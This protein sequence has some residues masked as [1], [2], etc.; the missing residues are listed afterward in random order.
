[1]VIGKIPRVMMTLLSA[2][3]WIRGMA[4]LSWLSVLNCLDFS[5]ASAVGVIVAL[6]GCRPNMHPIPQNADPRDRAAVTALLAFAEDVHWNESGRVIGISL[7]G[8]TMASAHVKQIAVFSDLEMLQLMAP[9][10]DED[11][12]CLELLPRLK[13][14]D[15]WWT[16]V[17]DAGVEHISSIETLKSL[18]LSHTKITDKSLEYL[19]RLENLETLDVE[20]T[21]V[22]PAALERFFQKRPK[23]KVRH[24]LQ[25]RDSGYRQQ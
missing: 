22:S 19:A 3:R 7:V 14:L 23:C 13:A 8:D 1:M 6:S 15:V 5:F 4:S 12:S 21:S 17:G 9:L 25:E 20:G 24:E 11:L 18:R 2:R 10:N 16:P